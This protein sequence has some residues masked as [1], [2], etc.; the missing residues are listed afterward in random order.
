MFSR[1]CPGLNEELAGFAD[2]LRAAP[3]STGSLLRHDLAYTAL[4]SHLAL[5]PSMTALPVIP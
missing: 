3:L 5:L 2:A 1:W 4:G